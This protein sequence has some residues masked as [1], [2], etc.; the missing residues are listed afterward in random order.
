MAFKMDYTNVNEV[1]DYSPAPLGV[2]KLKVGNAPKDIEETQSR[3]GDPMVIFYSYI[4]NGPYQGKRVRHSIV[5]LP[6]DSNGAGFA[7]KMLKS[8]GQPCEGN[9]TVNPNNWR[10]KEFI[11]RVGKDENN[12]KVYNTFETAETWAANDDTAP[13]LGAIKEEAPVS[14]SKATVDLEEVPF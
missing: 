13:E 1:G 10:G 14:Q 2:Y 5:F 9:I 6:A 11:A 3:N 12:G 8:L 7:K 4:A